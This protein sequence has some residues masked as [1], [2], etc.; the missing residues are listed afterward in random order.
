MLKRND[1]QIK[2][3]WQKNTMN[4]NFRIFLNTCIFSLK[5]WILIFGKINFLKINLILSFQS[6]IKFL[7]VGLFLFKIQYSYYFFYSSIT[8]VPTFLTIYSSARYRNISDDCYLQKLKQC[9]V[10]QC[11]FVVPFFTILK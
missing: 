11:E 7:I 2:L 9:I 10:F 5:I 4:L 8:C 6:A 1:N 3:V